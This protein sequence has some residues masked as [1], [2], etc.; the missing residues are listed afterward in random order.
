MNVKEVIVC[1]TS[2]FVI[3]VSQQEH[4]DPSLQLI[5]DQYKKI[6]N[7]VS[8]FINGTEPIQETLKKMIKEYSH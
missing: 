4:D 5:V 2:A 3:Y 7:N 8:V 1:N 6:C